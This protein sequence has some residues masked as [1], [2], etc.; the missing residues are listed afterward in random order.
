MTRFYFGQPCQNCHSDLKYRSSRACVACSKRRSTEGK[1][2]Y[3][4]AQRERKAA[5]EAA[6]RERLGP[7]TPE[8]LAHHAKLARIRRASPRPWRKYRMEMAA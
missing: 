3:T 1:R 4:A 8:Q 6:R 7:A 2:N 5:V